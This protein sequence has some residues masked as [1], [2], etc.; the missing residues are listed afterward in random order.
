MN[1]FGVYAFASILAT[2]STI[3][4]AY[5]TKFQ[6]FPTM[7]FLYSSKIALIVSSIKKKKNLSFIF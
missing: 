7:V 3:Y 2:V 5:A 4:Y 1:T 6:F